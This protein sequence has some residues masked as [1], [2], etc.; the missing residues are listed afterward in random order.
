VILF[1]GFVISIGYLFGTPFL[2]SGDV[3]PPAAT[4][5]LTLMFLG[6]GLIAWSWRESVFLEPFSG[7]MAGARLI[8]AILP[9][10]FLAILLEAYFSNAYKIKIPFNNALLSA[11]LTTLTLVVTT[12]VIVQIS[13]RVFR[14]ADLAEKQQEQS[15]KLIRE[16]EEKLELFFS[17][18]LDG[19]FFMMMDEPVEWKSSTD[20]EKALD[21]I[22]SHQRI[23]KINDAMLQQYGSTREQ[24]IG[25]TP[26][27]LFRHDPGGGRSLWRDF[28]DKGKLHVETDER[29]L[30]GTQLFVE[31][32]YICLYDDQGRITGHFGIQ[33]DVTERKMAEQKILRYTEELKESNASKDK[34]FSII[35]HDLKSPFS[36]ILGFSREMINVA[37]MND[38]DQIE[39]FANHIYSSAERTYELLEN[40]LQWAKTQQ[41]TISYSPACLA[42]EELL[43]EKFETLKYTAI[44]KDITLDYSCDPELKVT[45]DPEML[46]SILRN[47]I[48]NAIKFTNPG[49]RISI[50]AAAGSGEEVEV[51]VEDDGVGMRE[52]DC[53]RLFRIDQNVSRPGTKKE[54]GTG[55]GLILCKEFVEKNGGR[56]W[57]ESEP[58]KGTR[59]S[60]TLRSC[61]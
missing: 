21:Y 27:N 25:R 44:S 6:C 54:R 20:K 28:F 37:R 58:G 56:I 45:A 4:S 41:G 30:D 12:V 17:Q 1:C 5:A 15:R 60:F 7:N 46:K 31:G 51:L 35:S 32:D 49:G 42:L 19:F 16:G 52:E 47:L 14:R 53:Q 43:S 36:A 11:V 8:R 57:V 38:P 39:K 40:L 18:S 13:K 29:R 34:F 61:S 48:T 24:F 9:V 59:V 55:L 22:F 50:R 33:R 3:R 23:T 26:A 2:Y 10:I